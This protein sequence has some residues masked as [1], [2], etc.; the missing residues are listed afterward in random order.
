MLTKNSPMDQETSD[1][2]SPEAAGV[3]VRAPAQSRYLPSDD[4]AVE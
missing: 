4:Q 1:S 3:V 2:K